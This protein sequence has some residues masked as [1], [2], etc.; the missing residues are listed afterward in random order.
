MARDN[1][2]SRRTALKVT[3]AA[4]TTALLAGCSGGD[5]S[6]N[7]NGNG[8]SEGPYTIE[9]GTTIELKSLAQ[10]WEGVAPSK[11]EGVENPDLSLTEGETYTIEWVENEQG[12]H[13]LAVYDDS[14]SA[15]AGPTE[16][17]SEPSD[18]SV[19]FEASSDTVEYV[20]EPHYDIGMAGS[21][22]LE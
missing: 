19:E 9:S 22:Q 13:N 3:G 17:T 18:A 6:G 14:Q 11:I 2:V 1:P 15:V 21:I 5:D 12:T 20:C 7:G 4:A 16:K 10:S 8:D